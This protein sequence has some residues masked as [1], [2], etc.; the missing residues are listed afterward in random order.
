VGEDGEIALEVGENEQV[1]KDLLQAGSSSEE[2]HNHIRVSW[3]GRVCR[4]ASI[5]PG[6]L[7]GVE[8]EGD[9][10]LVRVFSVPEVC[11][12]FVWVERSRLKEQVSERL[13]P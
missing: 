9:S 13:R 7:L 3:D 12:A 6:Q 5:R 8:F 1:A 11:T 10:L 4:L 2:V